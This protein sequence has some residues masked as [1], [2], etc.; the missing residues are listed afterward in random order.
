[1]PADVRPV[2]SDPNIWTSRG[3]AASPSPERL[4]RPPIRYDAS[5]IDRSDFGALRRLRAPRGFP[6]TPHVHLARFKPLRSVRTGWGRFPSYVDTADRLITDIV[7]LA[8]L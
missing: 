3:P 2:A 8:C 5:R 6:S 4:V 1:M 7:E